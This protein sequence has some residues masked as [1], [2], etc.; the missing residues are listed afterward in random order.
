MKI[1]E[2]GNVVVL[3]GQGEVLW[4]SNVSNA[5]SQS[6]AL[7]TDNGNLVLKIAPNGNL[8]SQ[9]FLHPTDTYLS[10][11]SANTKTGNNTLLMSW[12]SSSDPFIGS[13]SASLN[14]LGS[15][16]LFI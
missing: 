9:S 12:R 5:F 8:F 2:N 1:S 15:P 14:P 11:L 3:N 10:T 13:F 4:S 7:L 16:E 6:T